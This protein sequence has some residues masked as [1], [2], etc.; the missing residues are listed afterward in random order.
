M[1]SFNE[2]ESLWHSIHSVPIGRGV[3]GVVKQIRATVGGI[4]KN[5]ILK[6][7]GVHAADALKIYTELLNNYVQYY[8]YAPQMRS[9][10]QDFEKQLGEYEAYY[11]AEDKS[12]RA[13]KTSEYKIHAEA[14][15]RLLQVRKSHFVCRPVPSDHPYISIQESAEQPG[16]IA[17]TLYAYLQKNPRREVIKVI[18][19][20]LAEILST[21]EQVGILHADFKLDNIMVVQ[22]RGNTSVSLKVIDFGIAKLSEPSMPSERARVLRRKANEHRRQASD[23]DSVSVTKSDELRSRARNL[24]LQ[25]NRVNKQRPIPRRLVTYNKKGRPILT[26]LSALHHNLVTNIRSKK[27]NYVEELRQNAR[28]LQVEALSSV[29]NNKIENL[30]RR[31]GDLTQKANRAIK[32]EAKGLFSTKYLR[33][34]NQNILQNRPKYMHETFEGVSNKLKKKGEETVNAAASVLQKKWRRGRGKLNKNTPG[35]GNSRPSTHSNAN[36]RTPVRSRSRNSPG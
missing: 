15:Q 36:K 8:K 4:P 13:N 28:K 10:Q 3:H 21:F 29:E 16:Q 20:K 17:T 6:H 1:A 24:N 34:P 19:D 31:A 32:N 14:Y 33:F 7:H 18:I 11:K 35:G 22:K 27:N 5:L 23:I 26:E 30:L 2:V 12:A 9:K 25:A